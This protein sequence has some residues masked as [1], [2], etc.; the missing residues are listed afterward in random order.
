LFSDRSIGAVELDEFRIGT[1]WSDIVARP[2]YT[3]IIKAL[4]ISGGLLQV[5]VAR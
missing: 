3:P 4:A 5:S 2:I 1:T